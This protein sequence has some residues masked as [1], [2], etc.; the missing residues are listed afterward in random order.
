MI[1]KH[2][3]WEKRNMDVDAWE[4]ELESADTREEFLEKKSG[5]ESEY[6]VVRVPNHLPEW[7]MWLQEQGY[8]YIE[9][10]FSISRSTENL[11]QLSRLQERI[12][13]CT[14][15]SEMDD[16]D[17]EEL[18]TK[19][20]NGLF[21]SDRVYLDPYFTG[22]QAANRYHG[23][24]E[25]ELKREAKLYKITYKDK[26]VGFFILKDQGDGVFH[27]ALGGIYQDINIIG[28]GLAMDYLELKATQENGGKKLLAGVSS[29]NGAAFSIP[30]NLGYT[31]D[32]MMIIYV[33]HGESNE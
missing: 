5:F 22:E 16:S 9:T 11:P 15:Y 6:T 17:K 2:A 31:I 32:K 4:V 24:I 20:Q 27:S 21:S 23:W 29:N 12:I 33:K 25:D 26:T 30:M 3:T 14:S 19:I 10:M 13:S 18:Y 8:R 28:I 7:G 1:I